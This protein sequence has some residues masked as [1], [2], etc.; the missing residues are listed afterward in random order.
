MRQTRQSS[1]KTSIVPVHPA[2]MNFFATLS[3]TWH[4]DWKFV[5]AF[6]IQDVTTRPL[7]S[8]DQNFL[9]RN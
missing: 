4:N 9:Y 8:S 5:Q 7:G 1:F 3:R 6:F 2:A